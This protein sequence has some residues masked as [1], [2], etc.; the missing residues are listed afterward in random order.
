M[1]IPRRFGHGHSLAFGA[2]LALAL[3]RH[4]LLA[5]VLVFVA[6]LVAGRAW[7][8]WHDVALALRMRLTRTERGGTQVTP[9]YTVPRPGTR[10]K[11]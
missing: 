7:A 2:L 4:A 10:R 1:K 9:R 6:G 8:F 3:E 5:L 11:P